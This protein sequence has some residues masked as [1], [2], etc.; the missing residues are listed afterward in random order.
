MRGERVLVTGVTGQIAFPMARVL[1]E[2]NEVWG[3][4]RFRDPASRDRVD[5]I[6]VRPVV[7]D[8]ASGELANVPRDVSVVLH[9]AANMQRGLDYDEA[10][11][12]N[13]EGTGLL[14]EH[15]R[16]ARAALVMSTQSVYEPH[17]DPMHVYSETDPLGDAHWTGAATYSVSKIGQESVARFCSRA[18]DLPVTIAR[19]N[20]SY[21]PNGGLL[22]HHLGAVI[23]ERPVVARWNP[24]PYTPIHE[25]DINAQ[26]GP[27]L[28]AASTPATI[29]NWGG[30]QAVSVQE[31][32]AYIAELSDVEPDVKVAP[33]ANTSRGSIADNTKRLAI[34]GPCSVDW[35]DGLRAM[36]DS[37]VVTG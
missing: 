20:A 21:G 28:D 5:S 24:C 16:E 23:A 8:L 27:L 29:V 19:M 22:A 15:C 10:L 3:L 36:I 11:R 25:D 7:C 2:H 37:G 35:R 17:G 30:D 1:A 31:W 18:F 12:H 14:L 4:A 13:A 6:G 34:T 26:V 32:C 9:L 33:I